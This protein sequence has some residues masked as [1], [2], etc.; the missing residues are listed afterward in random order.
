ME[1]LSLAKRRYPDLPDL[2]SFQGSK[3]FL[4]IHPVLNELGYFF[5]LQA[6]F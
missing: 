4:L 1:G 6:A 2:C 3:L 5:H